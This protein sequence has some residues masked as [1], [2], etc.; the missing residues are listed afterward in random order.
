MAV[1]QDLL[2]RLAQTLRITRVDP[3]IAQ[4]G[5]FMRFSLG[6]DPG[7]LRAVDPDLVTKDLALALSGAL[8][9]NIVSPAVDTTGTITEIAGTVLNNIQATTQSA[10]S[11]VTVR[12]QDAAGALPSMT[13]ALPI[14]IEVPLTVTVKWG[15]YRYVWRRTAGHL[16]PGIRRLALFR[17]RRHDEGG[18]GDD[19]AAPGLASAGRGILHAAVIAPFAGVV[20]VRLALLEQLAVAGERVDPLRAGDVA[21]RAVL[22]AGVAVRP[23]DDQ[24]F[25]LEQPFVPGD[26]LGQALE[27]RGGLENELL[28]RDVL[29]FGCHPG[30]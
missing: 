14:P 8:T 24:P 20:H 3:P 27:R 17:I 30:R 25:L 12:L 10:T 6:P 13:G 21:L 18:I 15:A 1:L 2:Q 4:I 28:H 26:Q 23:F 29:P 11:D 16:D 9:G 5:Q 7:L 22:A 19:G